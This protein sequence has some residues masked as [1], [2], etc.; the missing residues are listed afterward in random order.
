MH[1]FQ[2]SKQ[3]NRTYLF[4]ICTLQLQHSVLLPLCIWNIIHSIYFSH[5][6]F[7]NFQNRKKG[8]ANEK[9]QKEGGTGKAC[10][11][12]PEFPR[13]TKVYIYIY[14]YA[15]VSTSRWEQS[16]KVNYYEN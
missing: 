12:L 9:D 14:M 7:T 6:N 4:Q 15:Y 3:F 5:V 8:N 10:N 2:F 16:S 1:R 13:Y 11:L